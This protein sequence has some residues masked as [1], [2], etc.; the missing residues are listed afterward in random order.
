MTTTVENSRTPYTGISITRTS[1]PF[2]PLWDQAICVIL[3][4]HKLGIRRRVTKDSNPDTQNDKPYMLFPLP[5]TTSHSLLSIDTDE[6]RILVTKRILACP[7]YEAILKLY[8]MTKR[9]IDK[10]VL[11]S[12]MKPGVYLIPLDLLEELNTI[13]ADAR[14]ALEPLVTQFC[15]VYPQCIANDKLHLKD[16]YNPADYPNVDTVRQTFM[17]ETQYITWDL[18][19]SLGSVSEALIQQEQQ[20]ARTKVQT[21]LTDI[22]TNLSTVMQELVTHLVDRLSPD[23][24][25]NTKRFHTST[26]TNLMEFIGRFNARNLGQSVDLQQIVEQAKG[27][28]SGINP[29]HIRDDESAAQGLHT[30][31]QHVK[32]QLD[33]LL[34]TPPTRQY[35]WDDAA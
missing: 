13:L 28:L 20:R 22:T 15:Q 14:L 1:Q 30:G 3:T 9:N 32:R 27:L 2:R 6:A 17:I 24:N 29:T 18:P 34:A 16:A 5:D 11:P 12:G 26:V 10:L 21:I 25:G 7:E 35:Q 33:H 4:M 31:M 23:A 19:S 8:R